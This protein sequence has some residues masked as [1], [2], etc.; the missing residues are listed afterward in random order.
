MRILTMLLLT[1]LLGGC[2][3]LAKLPEEAVYQRGVL[4]LRQGSFMFRRCGQ[5]HWQPALALAAPLPE[6]YQRH[7]GGQQ[8]LPLYV[9]GWMR[10]DA[11]GWRVL[12][13][14]V[15]GGGLSACEQAF[16]GILLL[17][18]GDRPGWALRL[19]ASR[20]VLDD[21]EQR[22]RLIVHQPDFIRRGQL[23]QWKG[24]LTMQGARRELLFE[25]E[26]RPCR[27]EVG[28]WYALSAQV[29][30]DGEAFLGCARYG[31]LQ[32]LDLAGFYDTGD[33]YLRRV[34]LLLRGDGH[35][36]LVEDARNGQPLKVRLGRWQWLAE[37]RL[38]LELKGSDASGVE[39]TLLLSRLKD[40]RLRL[41]GRHPAYGEGLILEPGDQPLQWLGRPAL[42]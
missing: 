30:L 3:L 17:A 1:V 35:L 25:V 4:A 38:L 10:Q 11:D 24:Q 22:R 39:D 26:R 5:L 37:G 8:E 33:A 13:P 16:P 36:R 29:D 34:A 42:P 41:V 31:D 23:W 9:E 18:E 20:M 32:L 12:Q 6:E 28:H 14:R 27:D 19:E 7:S 21:P 40:G 2:Q 15:I